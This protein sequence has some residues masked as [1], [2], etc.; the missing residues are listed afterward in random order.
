MQFTSKYQKVSGHIGVSL[1]GRN[2]D[3]MLKTD[4]RRRI[5]GPTEQ[6]VVGGRIKLHEELHNTHSS[7]NIIGVIKSKTMTWTG[8]VAHMGR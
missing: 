8:N 6:K 4:V 3:T 5:F 7:R 2:I 1:F